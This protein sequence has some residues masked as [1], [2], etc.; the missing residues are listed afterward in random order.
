MR[1]E[2]RFGRAHACRTGESVS[3]GAQRV[4]NRVGHGSEAA[5][6][7]VMHARCHH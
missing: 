4:Q 7:C 1:S 2:G 3:E 5:H 6:R